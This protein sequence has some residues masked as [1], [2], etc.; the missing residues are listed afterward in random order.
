MVESEARGKCIMMGSDPMG[1]RAAAAAA[2]CGLV[3][4]VWCILQ[5]AA[6]QR[7]P[8][9]GFA[10][11]RAALRGDPDVWMNRTLLVRGVA[12]AC[13][14]APAGPPICYSEHLWF[15]GAGRAGS[16]DA[17]P[18]SLGASSRVLA[19]LRR[20]PLVG[21]LAPAPQ[22]PHWGTMATYRVQLRAAP[23]GSCPTLPC[24]TVLLLDAAP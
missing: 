23:G 9:Y 21:A 10:E 6:I 1:V 12:V 13:T 18:L 19:T 16:S 24:Y 4:L 7:E 15:A 8:V 11:V 20:I 2:L 3:V 22:L 17:L 14:P 5:H